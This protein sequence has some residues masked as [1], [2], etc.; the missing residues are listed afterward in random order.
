MSQEITAELLREFLEYRPE[1]GNLHWKIRD[2]KWFKDE[3]SA[4]AWN[5]KLAGTLA[6]NFVDMNG[7]RSGTVLGRKTKSHRVI[8][9]MVTGQKPAQIDHINGVRTDNRWPNLRAV[10][11][12]EN[13]KNAKRSKSNTSGTT[14]V[15]W[16]NETRKWCARIGGDKSRKHLGRFNNI[17]DAIAARKAAEVTLG[18]HPNHGRN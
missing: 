8:W 10:D 7:Y 3:R 15:F 13:T 1:T 18:F 14:G 12:S 17:Q 9:L 4:N 5:A 6:F 16:D 11:H 2:K